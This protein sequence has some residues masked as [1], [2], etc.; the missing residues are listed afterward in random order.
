MLKKAFYKIGRLLLI[1]WGVTFLCGCVRDDRDDC[2]FPLRL[3]FSYTY[4]REQRDL[5][6]EEIDHLQ[7]YL[8]DARSGALAATATPACDVLGQGEVFEWLV[9]PGHYHVVAWGGLDKR[10]SAASVEQF[11]NAA[12]RALRDT[13]GKTCPQLAEHLWHQIGHDIIV[14]GDV[15]PV[16]T[17]DMHKLS[18][19]V[20]V[21][22]A[23]LP[24]DCHSRLRCT[25]EASNGSYDFDGKRLAAGGTVTWLPETETLD[26]ESV[27]HRF[28]VLDLSRGDDSRLL[29]EVIP[30][31]ATRSLAG[32]I[33][34]GSLSELLSANPDIDLDLDD[35]FDIRLESAL[36]PDGRLGVRI[37]VAEWLVVDMHGGLG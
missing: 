33:F 13:D 31:E 2:L 17:L 3:R 30:D 16:R 5:F 24:A 37:Y 9:A 6:G 25:I 23:G 11:G 7:L 26:T 18:N 1:S 27:L 19:D 28:T 29:V 20:R 22:V 12:M 35:E 8:F 36:L 14:D 4:N 32:V 15:Q 34:D 21:E 10:Y